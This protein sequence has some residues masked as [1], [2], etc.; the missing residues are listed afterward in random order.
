MKQQKRKLNIFNIIIFLWLIVLTC[1][2]IYDII[3]IDELEPIPIEQLNN[4]TVEE[5]EVQ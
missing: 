3:R 2:L 4:Y 5:L 1:Y